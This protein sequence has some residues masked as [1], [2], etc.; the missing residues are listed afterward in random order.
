MK[1]N[2]K[3]LGLGA[4]AASSLMI[5]SAFSQV[6]ISGYMEAG[7][8]TGSH[9]GSTLQRARGKGLGAETVITV[10]G[11]GKMSNGWEY[12]IFQNLDSDDSTNGL[13]AAN[14]HPLST[15]FIGL[16]PGADYTLWYT[17]DGVYGGEIARTAIPVL[18]ERPADITGDATLSEFIDVTS[19]GHALGFDV[20]NL[21]PNARLSV[22]YNPM[23]DSLSYQ[24]S[25]RTNVGTG[26]SGQTATDASGY[27]I[28]Y[29]VA[30]GPVRVALGYTKINH[31]QATNAQDAKSKTGGLTFTQAPFAVGI[32]RT[33]ND[34]LKVGSTTAQQVKDTVDSASVTYAMSKEMSVGL[35]YSE[36]ERTGVAI[37][38]V[39]DTEVI[40][41]VVAY[42]LGPVVVSLAYE[43]TDNAINR[44]SSGAS[45]LAAIAGND[46][47]L[48][49]VKVK[50]NF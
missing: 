7:F 28:G 48:T 37:A 34:G 41:A 15:R 29:V 30:P 39:A 38:K 46:S 11:K 36:M 9:D 42:N 5:T 31:Q 22:A 20:R 4:I 13:S 16:N 23:L 35:I 26:Q 12:N 43:K 27:S 18:T 19:G 17:Y 40:Q 47:T 21:G 10:A 50:A 25:D 32:Q 24:S 33:T 49:K 44:A 3:K 6:T 2:L 1:H 45:Q 8:L 14:V